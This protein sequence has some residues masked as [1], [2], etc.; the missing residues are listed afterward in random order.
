MLELKY[1]KDGVV[2][3]GPDPDYPKEF[4]EG[5]EYTIEPSIWH[6][7]ADMNSKHTG[8]VPI[9]R[10]DKGGK[11]CPRKKD[12]VKYK[13]PKPVRVRALYGDKAIIKGETYEVTA[14]IGK[15]QGYGKYGALPDGHNVF[16]KGV[17]G[18]RKPDQFELVP[19]EPEL[20]V[21]GTGKFTEGQT[22]RALRSAGTRITKGKTYKVAPYP[23]RLGGKAFI[24]LLDPDTGERVDEWGEKHFEA[25]VQPKPFPA[26]CDVP[27]A[28]KHDGDKPDLSL[29][30]RA[31]VEAIARA[32]GHGVRK[33]GRDN[34][35]QEPR[36]ERHRL[37]AATL[38]HVFA[39]LDGEATDAESGLSHI[40]HA[41][42]ALSMLKDGEPDGD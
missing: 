24:R 17:R 22:V 28:K 8:S 34:Y 37:L 20:K 31:A 21:C 13:P 4:S 2:T 15:P 10:N 6:T 39:D 35:R 29:V 14:F 38:R 12:L 3:V 11:G 27:G 33:Y 26:D 42:A 16:V 7:L 40:D 9:S 19:D 1:E 5:G 23:G 25:V 30:P 32:L 18:M 41:L 36:L